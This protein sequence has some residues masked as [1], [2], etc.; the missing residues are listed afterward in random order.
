MD[1]DDDQQQEYEQGFEQFNNAIQVYFMGKTNEI[2]YSC[3]FRDQKRGKGFED[4]I[5]MILQVININCQMLR[6]QTINEIMKKRAQ[7]MTIMYLKVKASLDLIPI[8]KENDRSP[9]EIRD[10]GFH[11]C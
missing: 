3:S 7:T 11:T 8:N 6:M 10:K 4:R 9:W 1:I 5:K 2:F